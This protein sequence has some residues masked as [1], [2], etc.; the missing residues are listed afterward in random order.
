MSYSTK[1]RG[2]G[3]AEDL[4]QLCPVVEKF[5]RQML[6]LL[7]EVIGNVKYHMSHHHQTTK[8]NLWTVT[9]NVY[10]HWVRSNVYPFSESA[11][12]QKLEA[13]FKAFKDLDNT[14]LSKRKHTWG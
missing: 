14:S 1:T 9:K 6:P 2:S 4:N 13:A 5:D 3:V 7:K 10:E 11:V 8:E 12:F